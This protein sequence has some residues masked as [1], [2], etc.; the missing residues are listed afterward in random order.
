MGINLVIPL[1]FIWSFVD[2]VGPGKYTGGRGGRNVGNTYR[3]RWL[4]I[5]QTVCIFKIKCPFGE[6]VP[7]LGLWGGGKGGS[8]TFL[9]KTDRFR[10]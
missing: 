9:I 8:K 10:S 7:F 6:V 4:K 3:C 5:M 2:S 1:A